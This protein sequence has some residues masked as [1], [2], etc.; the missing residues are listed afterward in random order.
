MPVDTPLVPDSQGALWTWEAAAKHLSVVSYG[1]HAELVR[2]IPLPLTALTS[3]AE[4]PRPAG[5]DPSQ[6]PQV[7]DPDL[8]TL[9]VDAAD[10]LWVITGSGTGS[11]AGGQAYASL[12]RL[13]TR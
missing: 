8:Q 4:Y 3:D 7:V 11:T 13:N 10:T 12:Y 5:I 9:V 6:L 2:S 1:P